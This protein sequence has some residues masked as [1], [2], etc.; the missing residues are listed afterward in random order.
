MK[1]TLN[2]K[3]HE[4]G[5]DTSLAQVVARL[6]SADRGIAV[7]LNGTV[8]P[9]PRWETITLSDDDHVEVL[10]AVQGG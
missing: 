9:R 4:I 7:A 8:V 5:D 10:T 3:A 2:G 6:T 1:V